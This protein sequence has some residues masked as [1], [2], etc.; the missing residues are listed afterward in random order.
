MNIKQ[1][2]VTEGKAFSLKDIGSD[3]TNGKSKGSEIDEIIDK[4]LKEIF[5]LQDM[6]YA[7]NKYGVLI[8]LQAMDA[9]GKD[10]IIKHIM[11]GLN[12]QGV[13]VKSFKSPSVEE[14]D[15]DY[16]WRSHQ[17][18]PERGNMSIFNRSYYEDVV[19]V[20]VHHLLA[21]ENIPEEFLKK[22]VWKERY[23]QLCD[24]EK[25]MYEN[26]I[27]VLKFFLHISNEE[28]RKR[29]LERLDNPDKNWKFS[30]AD[31][32]ERKYWKHYQEAYEE[33]ICQTSTEYAPWH[34]IP[35]DHKWFSHLLV[36]EILKDTLKKLPIKY[37]IMSDADK[38]A[39]DNYRQQLSKG[40]K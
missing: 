2:E 15:H 4:N 26:G 18:L 39:L 37:P 13:H 29:L 14:M 3:F 31:L 10:G 11:T 35:S 16:L 21:G 36:S 32:Q 24:F 38:S 5:A 6:L 30:A 7:Y 19:V 33:M 17:Y 8:I 23:R 12:P 1:F 40:E 27:V 9:A 34:I 25:Y 28:Q 20:K 22:D